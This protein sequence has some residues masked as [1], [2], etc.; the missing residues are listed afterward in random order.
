M[1]PKKSPLYPTYSFHQATPPNEGDGEH[2]MDILY[3]DLLGE[4]R[5][6]TKVDFNHFLGVPVS[7]LIYPSGHFYPPIKSFVL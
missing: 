3:R 6:P 5:G 4:Q 7:Q 2:R 1:L